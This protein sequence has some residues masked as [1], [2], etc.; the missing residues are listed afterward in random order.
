M[1]RPLMARTS[2]TMR[3]VSVG[4]EARHDLVEQEQRRL[5]RERARELETLAL[6]EREPARRERSPS[7]QAHLLE[8]APARAPRRPRAGDARGRRP[9]RCAAR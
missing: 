9:S 3:S 8:H 4:V 6:G 2:C 7:R 1:P 5:R